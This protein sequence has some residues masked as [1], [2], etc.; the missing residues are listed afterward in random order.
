MKK[1]IELKIPPDYAN[2]YE[3]RKRLAARKLKVSE[4]E[5]TAL[6]ITRRSIDARGKIP[7]FQNPCRCFY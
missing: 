1:E 7:G 4:S 5:I 6:Q 2:D 3:Y